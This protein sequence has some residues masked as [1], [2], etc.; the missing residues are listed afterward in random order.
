MWKWICETYFEP[1]IGRRTDARKLSAGAVIDRAQVVFGFNDPPEVRFDGE[2]QGQRVVQGRLE[3]RG[4]RDDQE[5][6]EEIG[7][8]F[9]FELPRRNP[10]Q[11]TSPPRLRRAAWISSSSASPTAS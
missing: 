9:S 10:T 4:A 8:I 5:A 2:V 1:E 7:D 6:E 11:D 3:M